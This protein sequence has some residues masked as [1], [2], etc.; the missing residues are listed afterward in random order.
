MVGYG[1]LFD[2]VNIFGKIFYKYGWYLGFICIKV[3]VKYLR[4]V[5]NCRLFV[6]IEEY[7]LFDLEFK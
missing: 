7:I 2:L 3:D 1:N 5:V 6:R 4:N